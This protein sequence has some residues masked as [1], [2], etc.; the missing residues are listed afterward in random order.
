MRQILLPLLINALLAAYCVRRRWLSSSGAWAG[1]NIGSAIALCLGWAGW[2]IL[3]AFFFGGTA[4]TFIGWGRKKRRGV[5]QGDQGRRGWRNAWANAGAGVLCAA[6]S[7]VSA[8][9]GR[10][11]L[12]EAWRW[13][14]VASFAA[15]LAD[16]LSS[17][18]GLLAGQMPRLI[19]TGKRVAIGTDG[20]ITRA[21]TL[22]GIAGAASLTLLGRF[23]DLVP[24]R[25][26]LPVLAAGL[27]GNLLDS[28][29]GA[30]LQRRGV[31]SNDTVNLANTLAGGALGFGGYWFMSALP[32]WMRVLGIGHIDVLELFI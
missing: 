4:A 31:L 22:M 1:F 8:R 14:F 30:T 10:A 28:Y 7:W 3:G 16:T 21:G 24:V 17:E 27:S 18:F 2:A 19:T 25:A 29:L 26:T 13:G 32:E 9:Q 23:L 12:A 11:D 5:A 15:A 6:L 20:G